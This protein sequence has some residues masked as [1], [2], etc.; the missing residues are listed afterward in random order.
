MIAAV[1]LVAVISS[2]QGPTPAPAKAADTHEQKRKLEQRK[3]ATNKKPTQ[4]TPPAVNSATALVAT[5]NRQDLGKQREKEPPVDWWARASTIL[6]TLFTGALTVLAYRQWRSMEKQAQYTRDTLAE[7][8]KSAD[9]ATLAADVARDTLKAQRAHATVEEF[10]LTGPQPCDF[11]YAINNYGVTP[12]KLVDQVICWII[13]ANLPE[14]P[15]Y[16]G[17]INFPTTI[18]VYPGKPTFT[19]V[20][21]SDPE[22]DR[23]F[24]G[25]TAN[26]ANVGVDLV[27]FGKITYD[28]V[29]GERHVT[30]WVRTYAGYGGFVYNPSAPQYEHSD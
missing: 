16:G 7:T 11:S 5:W 20:K 4:R 3:T 19:R 10:R 15:D 30:G 24:A 18:Y 28:D 23:A 26:A 13:T 1:L 25:L 22:I 9:A 2:S 27:M 14:T 21:I 12:A 6:V 17:G 29:F 8:K